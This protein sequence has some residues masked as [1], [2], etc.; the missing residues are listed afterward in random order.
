M[1]ELTI[2]SKKLNLINISKMNM[3]ISVSDYQRRG[4]EL[5]ELQNRLNRIDEIIEEYMS[6][7]NEDEL[8]MIR[9]IL[10]G[11]SH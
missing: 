9:E 10:K 11:E 7:V 1:N 5:L 4:K 8:S 3:I 2:S 6:P